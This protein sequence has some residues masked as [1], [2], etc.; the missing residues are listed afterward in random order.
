MAVRTLPRAWACAAISSCSAPPA[1][2]RCCSRRSSRGCPTGCSSL[3]LILLLRAEGFDYA[4]IGVVTAASGLCRR[5]SRRRSRAA[6]R[7]RRADARARRRPRCSAPWP[8]SRSSSRCSPA[9]APR[10]SRC[11]RSPAARPSRRSPPRCGRCCPGSSGRDRLDTAF[12][13]DALQLEGVFIT[14]PLLAAGISAAGLAAGRRAHRRGAAD[15]GRAR[16]RGLAV[17]P[18]LAAGAARPRRRR[19]AGAL[20]IP[21]LR[22][23]VVALAITAVSIGALEIGIPAFAEQEGTRSDSGWLFALW[24]V[25]SLAGGPLVRRAPRGAAGAGRRFLFVSP[26][27]RSGSR[28]SRSPAR[29]PSSRCSRRRRPRPRALDGGLLLVRRGARAGGRADRG[30]RVADRGLRRRLARSAPGSRAW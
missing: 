6:D 9:A 28:R 1:S 12:A 26:C 4:A 20:S 11:S 23:L 2:R 14:G 3:A 29:C 5:R 24:A 18:A 10:C 17:L 16:L 25:G 30:L 8:T 19:R 27:W 13:F 15:H 22:T 7:P 21:G